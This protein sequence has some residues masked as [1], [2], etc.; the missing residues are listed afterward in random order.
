MDTNDHLL[1][2]KCHTILCDTWLSKLV[3]EIE[4][5]LKYLPYLPIAVNKQPVIVNLD[6]SSQCQEIEMHLVIFVSVALSHSRE[7]TLQE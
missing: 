1:F 6:S 7:G 2:L 3:I 5:L 4:A